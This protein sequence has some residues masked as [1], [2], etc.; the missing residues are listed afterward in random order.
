MYSLDKDRESY[1]KAWHIMPNRIHPIYRLMMLYHQAGN[2]SK[3]V[4]YARI[5]LNH[6]EKV[7][8]PA[9][10]DIKRE[11]YEK[12]NLNNNITIQ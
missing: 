9:V 6:K 8:S 7:A 10:N 1:L 4:E 5:I 11:A 2:E 12:I 3:A